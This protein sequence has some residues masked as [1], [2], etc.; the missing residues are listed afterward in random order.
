MVQRGLSIND[1]SKYMK[2][3]SLF[4]TKK[5]GKRTLQEE[6]SMVPRGLE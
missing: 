6:S 3:D 1:Y 5:R 2:V 4:H